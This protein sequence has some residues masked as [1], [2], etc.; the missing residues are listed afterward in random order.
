MKLCFILI[1]ILS[2]LMLFLTYEIY[3]LPQCFLSSFK[4]TGLSVQIH[5]PSSS[6]KQF[7]YCV[8]QTNTMLLD[9][10]SAGTTI[11]FSWISPNSA[12]T[13][14]SSNTDSCRRDMVLLIR[15]HVYLFLGFSGFRPLLMNDRSIQVKYS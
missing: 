13:S 10:L 4:P 15:R 5:I 14:G 8:L 9:A 11:N 7:I 1:I 2:T 6:I 12:A 3:K